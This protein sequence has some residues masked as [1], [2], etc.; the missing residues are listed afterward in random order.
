MGG[1]GKFGEEMKLIRSPGRDDEAQRD[2]AE[3]IAGVPDGTNGERADR[4]RLGRVI[5]IRPTQDFVL[6]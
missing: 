5:V 4:L 2:S 3:W 1:L 6:G